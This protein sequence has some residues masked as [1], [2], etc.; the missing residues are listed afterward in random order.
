MLDHTPLVWAEISVND[1]SRA[2]AFYKEHFGLTFKYEEMNDMEMAIVET[3]DESVTNLALVKH[4][5]M[6]PSLEGSTIYLHLGDSLQAQV[7]ALKEAGVEI[8]LPA[9]PI[10]DGSCGSIAIFVDCEGNK[11]GLW[12]Q[13]M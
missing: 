12:S 11:I 5:M 6:K 10:K 8:L 7:N 1:M 2:Q 4:D 9:M 13:N 3:K